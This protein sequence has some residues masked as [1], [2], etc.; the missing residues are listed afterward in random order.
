MCDKD[1]SSR[2]ALKLGRGLSQSI[3][4]PIHKDLLS[5]K[6]HEMVGTKINKTVPVL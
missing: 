5:S 1:L 6:Y 3:V 4:N 2:G